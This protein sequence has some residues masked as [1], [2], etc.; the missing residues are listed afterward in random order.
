MTC[1][2][3]T[4]THSPIKSKVVC[5]YLLNYETAVLTHG[6]SNSLEVKYS[7]KAARVVAY[8]M[9]CAV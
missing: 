9:H 2:T 1:F 6:L 8:A 7:S 5:Q 4:L 3:A